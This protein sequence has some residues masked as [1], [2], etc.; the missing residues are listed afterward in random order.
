MITAAFELLSRIA[1]L[2]GLLVFTVG[3][4]QIVNGD[5]AVI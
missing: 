3:E 5:H 4:S 1:L 2:G